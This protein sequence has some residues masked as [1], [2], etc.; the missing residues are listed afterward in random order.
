MNTCLKA[1]LIGLAVSLSAFSD[2]EDTPALVKAPDQPLR[3]YQYDFY[4][5]ADY[6]NLDRGEPL[7]K[8]LDGETLLKK[9][10]AFIKEK[11]LFER[12]KLRWQ[13]IETVLNFNLINKENQPSIRYY[14][15]RY[16]I[17]PEN[18]VLGGLPGLFDVYVNIDGRIIGEAQPSNVNTNE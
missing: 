6:L 15:V 13:G 10:D 2:A 1:I 14:I 4:L 9:A 18:G 16:E 7:D 12:N 8:A 17:Y 5:Y 3:S 11:K